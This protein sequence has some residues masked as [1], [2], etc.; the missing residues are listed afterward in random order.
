MKIKKNIL[1]IPADAPAMPLNPRIPAIIAII[2][3]IIVQRNIKF[4][5]KV[6]T[7]RNRFLIFRT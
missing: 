5:F 1:A 3:N 6:N 2:I 4:E 7:I